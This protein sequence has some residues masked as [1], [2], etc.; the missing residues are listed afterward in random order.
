VMGL[1]LLWSNTALG[2]L[3]RRVRTR[4]FAPLALAR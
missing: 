3:V 2:W 1:A 4:P